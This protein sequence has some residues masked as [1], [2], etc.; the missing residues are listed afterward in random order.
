MRSHAPPASVVVGAGQGGYQTAASLPEQGYQ[1]R[2]TLLSAE[3]AL[4]YERPP[5]TKA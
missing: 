1:H 2:I 3:D 4:P 5:L